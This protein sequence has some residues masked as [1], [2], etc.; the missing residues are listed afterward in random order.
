MER[1]ASRL[2]KLGCQTLNIG[3][4]S[5]RFDLDHLA[6]HVWRRIE[7]HVQSQTTPVHFVTH[8]LGGI[9]L[10][11]LDREHPGLVHRAVMLAPPNQGT[12]WVNSFYQNRVFRSIIG[13][14]GMQVRTGN[15]Q[16]FNSLGPVHFELGVIAGNRPDNPA[17]KIFF[18]EPNDG[19][20]SVHSTR[21]PG[22]QSHLVLPLGHFYIMFP[23]AVIIQIANFLEKGDFYSPGSND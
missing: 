7:P 9:I 11:L 14:A 5:R 4:P 18:S 17:A 13:P 20:V 15:D 1:I 8:S 21:I 10:R 23:N 16:Y 6:T 12:R 3:Y 19:R 2:R 22:M